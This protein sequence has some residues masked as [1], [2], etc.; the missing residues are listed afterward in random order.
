MLLYEE[1][2]KRG[3]GE[4]SD[5]EEHT[6]LS[7]LLPSKFG[8]LL[9]PGWPADSKYGGKVVWNQENGELGLELGNVIMSQYFASNLPKIP[10][11]PISQNAASYIRRNLVHQDGVDFPNGWKEGNLES[12][13]Y[14]V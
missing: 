13:A 12:V 4:N 1:P 6:R 5:Y 11:Q 10:V 2:T 3:N 8:D 14:E 7:T 9:T